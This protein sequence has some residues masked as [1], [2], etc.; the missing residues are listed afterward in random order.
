MQNPDGTM[1]QAL[2]TDNKSERTSVASSHLSIDELSAEDLVE[3]WLKHRNLAITFM[4]L[5][6]LIEGVFCTLEVLYS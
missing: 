3:N 2:P 4:I 6:L 5:V 1:S